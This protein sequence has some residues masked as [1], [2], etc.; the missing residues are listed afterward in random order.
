MTRTERGRRVKGKERVLILKGKDSV[1]TGKAVP[2]AVRVVGRG[3][4]CREVL[5]GNDRFLVR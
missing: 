5:E 4:G 3:R 1:I 2:L